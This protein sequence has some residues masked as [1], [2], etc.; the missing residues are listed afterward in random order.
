MN[1]PQG[2]SSPL[3][4]FTI[5]ALIRGSARLRPDRAALSHSGEGATE[6]PPA[7]FGA[8]AQKTDALAASLAACGL[9]RGEKMLVLGAAEPATVLTL[10]AGLRLGLDVAALPLGG[11]QN[12]AEEAALLFAPQAVVAPARCGD[13]APAA[14]LFRLAGAAPSIRFVGL[15][16]GD[17][18]G[19]VRL[20][21]DGFDPAPVTLGQG[22]GALVTF[23]EGA[24]GLIAHRHA[25]SVLVAA[26]LDL[27]AM[28]QIGV[29]APILC[30]VSPT[31]F[32]GFVAGPILSLLSGAELRLHAPFD[33][34]G[35]RRAMADRP[36]HALVP[37][38]WTE[39]IAAEARRGAGL[40]TLLPLCPAGE[41]PHL[42]DPPC[43]VCDL[44]AI[45]EIALAALP[46]DNGRP[47]ALEGVYHVLPIDS[48]HIVALE[49]RQAGGPMEWRGAAVSGGEDWRLS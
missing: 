22:G 28:A 13:I 40:A 38:R 41:P 46:R 24:R 49:S 15:H 6:N 18:D 20:D 12:R 29:E 37:S 3:D 21:D 7:S 16:G 8:L 23:S 2:R 14:H 47:A 48:G 39:A 30:P 17:E 5:D 25:E 19:A 35:F 45:G 11:A 31:R 10:L 32:A 27:M 42:A 1:A 44:H 4:A 9:R 26:G 36:V 43:P 33:L 34:G